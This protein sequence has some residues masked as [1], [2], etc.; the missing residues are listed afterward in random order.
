M[1]GLHSNTE[2][3]LVCFAVELH[4]IGL[5]YFLDGFSNVTQ[6]HINASILKNTLANIRYKRQNLV[7]SMCTMVC[8]Y[9]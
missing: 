2:Q 4:L 1:D 7:C 5:H 9:V 8:V 6:T 3:T